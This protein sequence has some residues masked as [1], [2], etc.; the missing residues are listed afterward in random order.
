M[1]ILN[2][3]SEFKSDNIWPLFGQKRRK[4]NRDFENIPIFGSFPAKKRVKCYL[5]WI[6]RTDLESFHH[7]IN[8]SSFG[9]IFT[10]IFFFLLAMHLKNDQIGFQAEFFSKSIFWSQIRNQHPKIH[11]ISRYMKSISRKPKT[12]PP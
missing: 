4:L 7:F 3:A 8:V 10:F 9:I 1:R 5:I 2:L 11:H 6:L 12:E